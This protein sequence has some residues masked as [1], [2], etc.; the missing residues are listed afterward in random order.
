MDWEGFHSQDVTK[1]YSTASPLWVSEPEKVHLISVKSSKIG[2][3][4]TWEESASGLEPGRAL[5]V[6][7]FTHGK[8]PNVELS[9]SKQS[10]VG[11]LVPT[12]AFLSVG[13]KNCQQL[14]FSSYNSIMKLIVME[15]T[16]YFIYPD[17]N[18]AF[19]IAFKI[20]LELGIFSV[21]SG[22]LKWPLCE[23]WESPS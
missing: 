13:A 23:E 18:K 3:E 16:E 10:T 8:Y 9:F 1:T 6:G 11:L 19:D 20:Q 15:N 5:F 2:P 4:V 22:E 21:S 17:W 12:F 14:L 7:F